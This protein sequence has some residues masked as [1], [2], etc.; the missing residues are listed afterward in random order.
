MLIDGFTKCIMLRGALG[1]HYFSY[2]VGLFQVVATHLMGRRDKENLF[3]AQAALIA[4]IS[5]HRDTQPFLVSFL[6]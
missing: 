3:I 1:L 5:V 2:S 6:P 4:S